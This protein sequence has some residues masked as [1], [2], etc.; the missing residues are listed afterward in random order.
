VPLVSDHE[1]KG[2]PNPPTPTEEAATLVWFLD[3]GAVDRRSYA[4]V[5]RLRRFQDSD[6]FA[7][8]PEDLRA[9]IREIIAEAG[10]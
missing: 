3:T 2:R 10:R 8:L 9:R 7:S 4:I 5:N 1:E 6:Q